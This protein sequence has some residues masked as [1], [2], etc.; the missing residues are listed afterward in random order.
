MV[1]V[2]LVGERQAKVGNKFVFLKVPEECKECRLLNVCFNLEQGFRY[3]ITGVRDKRHD[4]KLHEGGVRVVEVKKLS[5]PV[6]IPTG[7]A[8]EGSSI[9]IS[10]TCEQRGCEFYQLC[11]PP[12]LSSKL[13]LRII[14]VKDKLKCPEGKD[15]T[16][17]LLE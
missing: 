10:P 3:E 1:L 13:K 12:N 7:H 9:S 8:I 6:A 4:C 14:K 5:I 16:E 11:S 2:T 15:L 17:A